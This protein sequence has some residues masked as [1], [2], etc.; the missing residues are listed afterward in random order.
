MMNLRAGVVVLLLA[1]ATPEV[2]HFRYERAVTGAGARAG[3]T[4]A[5]LDATVYEHAAPQLADVRLYRGTGRDAAETPYTI[6]QK[7]AVQPPGGTI[8]PLN[9]GHRGVQT[10]FEAEMPEGR[11]SDVTLDISAKNFVATVAV[12]GAQTGDGREGTELGLY[13]IFDLTAQ[14]LGRSMVLHLPES[15]YRYL[16]FAI[17]GPV[18]PEDV[19]GLT[20]ERAA[21]KVPFVTVA[22]TNQTIQKRHET[23]IRLGLPARAPVD[24]IVFLPQA[25]PRNF[26]RR[27]TVNIHPVAGTPR[28]REEDMPEPVETSGTLLRL[29]ALRDGHQIDEEQLTVEAP[30]FDFGNDGSQWTIT[31][32]NGDDA[33]LNIQSV[34][35]E[36]AERQ[37]CFDAAAGAAYTLFYGDAAL[38]SPRY[39]YATLFAPDTN[40]A[41]ARLGP[42]Q[43]NPAYETRPDRRPFTERHP[44]L[45]WLALILVVLVLGGVARRTAKSGALRS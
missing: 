4:C 42:E 35:L 7:P 13:T 16:Y 10:T 5:V 38:S 14:K 31:I 24:R 36:M 19:H 33:P 39:D 37:L 32:D 8:A 41:V 43:V 21:P 28:E 34:Q 1:A 22:T 40:A 9:L 20:A 2:R 18:K 15:N 23:V 29:H 27:V 30:R 44:E 17:R 6:W 3:Q 25:E 11:Y 26:S 45:L 12:T